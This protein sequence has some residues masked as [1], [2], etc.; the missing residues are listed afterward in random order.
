MTL[1]AAGLQTYYQ[2]LMEIPPGALLK[3]NNS[4][5]NRE[6]V[7]ESRR[8]I[9]AYNSGDNLLPA[10]AKQMFEY[11]GRILAHLQ[12]NTLVYDNGSAVFVPFYDKEITKVTVTATPTASSYLVLNSA[13]NTRK[14]VIWF[15]TTG[16]DIEPTVSGTFE[17]FK[18]D[19]SAAPSTQTI[20]SFITAT[21]NINI[22]SYF[23]AT[24][25]SNVVTITNSGVGAS[26]DATSSADPAP[27][28]NLTVSVTTQGGASPYIEPV[29][30]Y[31]MRSA[32]SK[33]NFYFT[34]TNGVQRISA[35]TAED[36][37]S[38][39]AIQQSGVPKGISGTTRVDYSTSG[40]L[41]NNQKTGYVVVWTYTDKQG[42]SMRGA[43][44]ATMTAENKSIVTDSS[45]VILNFQIPEGINQFN[46]TS[47]K[48][49]ICRTDAT[50]LTGTLANEYRQ[51]YERSPTFSEITGLRTIQYTDTTSE[52]LRIGGE[53]VY[54]N[55]ANGSGLLSANERPPAA[56]DIALFNGHMF[57]ANTRTPHAATFNLLTTTG[58]S[59]GISDLVI[60]N[61][62][63]TNSYTF[64]GQKQ[65]TQI[66]INPSA[67]L[68]TIKDGDYFT[69]NSAGNERKY[70]VWMDKTTN[71]AVQ[72]TS[73]VTVNA[74]L[75]VGATKEVTSVTVNTTL[76]V[77]SAKEVTSV[78]VSST[79]TASSYLVLNSALDAK[80]YVIWFDRT[81]TDAQPTVSGTFAYVRVAVL[82]SPTTATIAGL[83]NTAINTNL[84]LDFT[85]TV[86]TNIVTI[87]NVGAGAVTDAVSS[88]TPAAN[89]V[90]S[91]PTQGRESSYFILNS[92]LNTR[93]YVVWFDRSGTDLQPTV[94]GTF[95]Y[96]R[97]VTGAAP[98]NI[99]IAAAI[100]NAINSNISSDFTSTY[101]AGTAVV[102]ITNTGFGA[103][104]D[105]SQ[106][107]NPSANLTIS[108]TAQGS[109]SS[110]FVLYSALDYRKYVIWFDRSGV[111]L[112]P[113]V[114][115]TFGYI[116]V[117]T[118][119]VPTSATIASAIATQIAVGAGSDFSTSVSG[120]VVT[121]TNTA[122]GPAADPFQSTAPLLPP[123]ANLTITTTIQGTGPL[124]GTI[125][126]RVY[127]PPTATTAAAITS[128]I[129][130]AIRTSLGPG[131]VGTTANDF[132]TTYTAGST[133]F[134]VS[135]E[136]NGAAEATPGSEYTSN[137]TAAEI[138]TITVTATYPASSSYFTLYSGNQ[139]QYVVWFD[140]TGVDTTPT[141]AGTYAYIRVFI[142]ASP[143]S[144]SAV[145]TAIFNAL[146]VAPITSDFTCS[147][148]GAV[149][150]ITNTQTNFVVDSTQSTSP[151]ASLTIAT[152]AQGSGNWLYSTTLQSGIGEDVANK[153][154]LISGKLD[155][156]SALEDMAK[157]IVR[158]INSNPD[159]SVIAYYAS[160]SGTTPGKIL[161]QSKNLQDVNFFV[162]T[163]D[164]F[165]APKFLPE[166]GII[167]QNTNVESLPDTTP[168]SLIDTASS[169]GFIPG[170][171]V[172]IYGASSTI[173]SSAPS[174]NG[175]KTV[176]QTIPSTNQYSI[177]QDVSTVTNAGYT[178]TAKL[179][180]TAETVGNRIYYAKHQQPEAVPVL[181]YEDVGSKDQEILRIIALRDSLYIFKNDGIFKI[182][183]EG[184]PTPFFKASIYD[185][186]AILKA[187]DTVVALANQCYFYGNQGI[188]RLGDASMESISRPIED[189]V[190]PFLKSNPNLS[191]AAFAVGYESDRALL[192]WTV[193]TKLDTVATVCLRYNTYTQTWTEWEIPKRCAVLNSHQDTMYFGSAVDNYIEVERKN[194]D[195]FDYADR[196]LLANMGDGAL[197]GNSLYLSSSQFAL[198]SVGD[199]F[200]QTQ[201]VSITQFNSLLKQLDLDPLMPS[202]TFYSEIKLDVGADLNARMVELVAKLNTV[203]TWT[204]VDPNG[205]TS[206]QFI[207]NYNDYSIVQTQFNKIIDRLNSSPN[208]Q[209]KNYLYSTGT[210]VYECYITELEVSTKKIG[211][212]I[213]PAFMVGP[214]SIFKG[215]PVEIQ[216]AP[217]HGGDPESFKQFSDGSFL[218]ERRSFYSGQVAYNSDISDHFEEIPL[219]PNS[220]GIFGGATWGDGSTWGGLGD[221]AN[222]RS[223]I[224][225]KKQ[226]CRFLG[227][228]FIHLVALENFQLY[229]VSLSYRT[230]TINNRDYR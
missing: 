208:A 190:I 176:Y 102:T 94:S 73:T 138:R 16:T 202:T 63:T 15:D 230:Y 211:L 21:I 41:S 9:K 24:V 111:D 174:L 47:Y 33:G 186:T 204:G 130:T 226:R 77:G 64:Q 68:A 212:N 3:A 106:S 97:I 67:T 168:Y 221:Q 217:Q 43:P 198:L 80:K 181:N 137:T 117:L 122:A 95:A 132:I 159:E 48:F 49:A 120:S 38:I 112:Q 54:T 163:S 126:L 113:T 81:G 222:L 83:I 74:T 17:Y 55:T 46:Y 180:S 72:Q 121:I 154:I 199:V 26:I 133:S 216:Y 87:T 105:N 142:G 91:V 188:V 151:A 42:T 136:N 7:I 145:A 209:Y 23:T 34:T 84:N 229:G 161:L 96:L 108:T 213:A 152:T 153:K 227:C 201:Y 146:N 169:F 215:I 44:S 8:G 11:K 101:T 228:K 177:Q 19:I 183:G 196:E 219:F 92:A 115:N 61:G 89:L 53:P 5:I 214:L 218:F 78:T 129:E 191:T 170:D 164:T 29:S 118:G 60:S 141:V 20:A 162:G 52:S 93:K 62:I 139:R 88:T 40:F 131:P 187:P 197:N 70:T 71:G 2:S 173:T 224:P 10:Q 149:V 57:Y 90:V 18:I 135:T 110:Y 103:T 127:L 82:G 157:S 31:R 166:L 100:H 25:S 172:L 69:L 125:P 109:A 128:A 12:N 165:I 158:V 178:M 104:T 223:Y 50:T 1:K 123:S 66:S 140:R 134:T 32:E 189:K 147:V 36:L 37:S 30:G 14:Y 45:A 150:T 207:P 75:P 179:M 6:G 148:S 13:L 192:L 86:S 99:T 56:R 119:A 124:P 28:S 184:G 193:K 225:L 200:S 167:V 65:T 116:R 195:R 156:V 98:T 160:T 182:N 76:P 194:F 114:P 143:A 59:S 206:Y 27:V 155:L 22:S 39:D 144:T 107:T 185:N 220:S 85:S 210:K 51:I 58:F 205:N 79:P 203:D 4:I 175:K 171:T 35:K